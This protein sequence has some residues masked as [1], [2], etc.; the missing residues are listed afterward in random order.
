[1]RTAPS[2]VLKNAL[3]RDHFTAKLT[4]PLERRNIRIR[5]PKTLEEWA[6]F[7]MKEMKDNAAES[8]Q[9]VT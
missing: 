3:Q 9:I 4:D 1:M 2:T 8:R 6:E 7:L 5:L